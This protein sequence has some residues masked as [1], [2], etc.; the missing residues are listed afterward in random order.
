[1]KDIRYIIPIK[2]EPKMSIAENRDRMIYWTVSADTL[3]RVGSKFDDYS[4]AME[5]AKKYCGE[6]G[7]TVFI[8]VSYRKIERES[9]PFRITYFQ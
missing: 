3:E 5:R 4:A 8:F 7:E 1:M 2:E 9:V 6:T